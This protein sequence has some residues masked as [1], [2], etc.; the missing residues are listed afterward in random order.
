MSERNSL[1]QPSA[2]DVLTIGQSAAPLLLL[3]VTI[4]NQP[5]RALIDSGAASSWVNSRFIDPSTSI[6]TLDQPLLPV[7]FSAEAAGK[8]DVS[9]CIAN[10]DISLPTGTSRSIDPFYVLPTLR[11]DALLGLDWLRRHGVVADFANDCLNSKTFGH[12]PVLGRIPRSA[13]TSI[14][15]VTSV[16][17]NMAM[18]NL[19]PADWETSAE[20]E[21]LDV[22]AEVTAEELAKVPPDFHC[23]RD[24]FSKKRADQLPP[25][26][27]NIDI[28]INLVE[29]GEQKLPRPRPYHLGP[30]EI[31]ALKLYLDDMLKK[32]FIR[33]S[34]SPI[35]FPAFF[36]SKAGTSDLRLVVDYKSLNSITIKDKYAL[37]L[38]AEI[39]VAIGKGKLLSK[40]DLRGA[41]NLL[42]VA[43]GHEY[44]T[45]FITSFGTYEFLVMPFGLSNAPSAFQ[46]WINSI[47]QDLMYKFVMVYLDDIIIFSDDHD[48][49]TAHI[50][51][52]LSR[53]A[54]NRLY[55]S[56]K[57]CEWY[58]TRLQYLGHV[59]TPTT[60]EMCED[61]LTSIASWQPPKS[62][63]GI[64]RFLGFANYYRNF[65]ASF[66]KLAKPLTLLLTKEWRTKSG[67]TSVHQEF[68]LPAQALAAFNAIVD[69]FGRAPVLRHY[70]PS[71]PTTL[72]TDASNFAMG[73]ILSQRFDD[74]WHPIAY[75]SRSFSPAEFNYDTHDKELLAFIEAFRVWRHYLFS[76]QG[77]VC[78]SDHKNLEAFMTTKELSGRQLR[79]SIF[80]SQFDFTIV[81]QAGLQ[82]GR[83]DALS[84][85]EELATNL[86][87]QFPSSAQNLADDK[88][89]RAKSRPRPRIFGSML[90]RMAEWPAHTISLEEGGDRSRTTTAVAI[91]NPSKPTVT[92][93]P[94]SHSAVNSVS[95]A[96]LPVPASQPEVLGSTRTD[97]IGTA[98]DDSPLLPFLPLDYGNPATMYCK[99][100]ILDWLAEVEPATLASDVA[101]A[102]LINQVNAYSRYTIEEDD[103]TQDIKR[104]Q[105]ALDRATIDLLLTSKQI[106]K[107]LVNGKQLLLCREALF[108]PD[109]ES[110]RT[111]ALQRHHD[112]RLVGHPG[113]RKTLA[114]LNR[115][116]AWPGDSN[117]VKNYVASCQ[118]CLRSK[119]SRQKKFGPLRPLEAPELPWESV[120]VDRIVALP[121]SKGFTSIIVFVDRFSKMAKFFPVM[122]SFNAK[123]LAE[124]FVKEIVY[125]YGTP[126][127]IISDRGPE[128]AS[129]LWGNVCSLLKMNRKLSTAY[130]PE[131]DGQTERVN[132]T[133]EI[134]LRQN[135]NY[136]QSDWADLLPAAAFCYN[137]LPHSAT[138][139]SPFEVLYNYVPRMAGTYILEL[140]SKSQLSVDE[141][142]REVKQNL[143]D[144]REAAEQQF[145]KHRL[146]L[147]EFKIGQEV[148]LSGKNYKT[149]RPSKKLDNVNL[150]PFAIV[151]KVSSHA[152]RLKLQEGMKIHDVFHVSLLRPVP[153]DSFPSRRQPPPPPVEIEGEREYVVEAIAAKKSIGGKAM[154]KVKWL[155]YRGDEEFTWEPLENVQ[156]TQAYQ[157][158]QESQS[159]L[160]AR[161]R[162]SK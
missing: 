104:A 48:S 23:Y 36:V 141:L 79:W 108:V 70:D 11:F 37:P 143:I 34:K 52:V 9:S 125:E 53:L 156:D 102:G 75:W 14:D 130:H 28:S 146:P 84:R 150:G 120:T 78:R 3:L 88:G 65:I 30:K 147:P 20:F 76:L 100:C 40:I 12:L 60:I 96:L 162:K 158:F 16:V 71:R 154:F 42:R 113:T 19:T 43:K 63:K 59:I 148:M 73:A 56:P 6:T 1:C 92:G 27:P 17:A 153:A 64:E 98:V 159:L 62:I 133:L 93:Q 111:R 117:D 47:F 66:S 35:A 38:I 68:E 15:A 86:L 55:A 114:V 31:D 112:D 41:Y 85:R 134:Y 74:G 118:T 139:H 97:T 21:D 94:Q 116:Y 152:Y 115:H 129:I 140:S 124:L 54:A 45:A 122:E 29:G 121:P 22:D 49:H 46:R 24:V 61:K 8:G 131:T 103:L 5:A 77:L 39:L 136:H 132:Q 137:S 160:Q 87:D 26:R 109:N 155:G 2:S 83:C 157:E 67:I 151:E 80:L 13:L 50:H 107:R 81:F 128:F 10:L 57:K 119:P 95:Q 135:C 105:L 69:A 25:H 144:A 44:K 101:P 32:G 91:V 161:K 4:D 33:P 18:P 90:P 72:E 89:P 127:E 7:G 149:T 142:R 145:N 123:D 106:S 138:Q 58:S 110:L 99:G 82:N 51:E 126:L